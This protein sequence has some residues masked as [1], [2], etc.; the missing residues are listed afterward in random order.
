MTT[1]S[2]LLE[3]KVKG[4]S[5]SIRLLNSTLF[6]DLLKMVYGY[7]DLINFKAG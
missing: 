2:G 6:A 7:I 5:G 1:K 3:A 4:M